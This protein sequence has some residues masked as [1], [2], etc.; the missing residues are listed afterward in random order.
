[1]PVRPQTPEERGVW[2]ALVG[3]WGAYLLGAVYVVGPALGWLLLLAAAA[4]WCGWR[5]AP[6]VV[7]PAAWAWIV[8]MLLMQAALVVGHLDF[9]LGMG[10]LLKSSVGWA[11]GWALL[12]AFVVAGSLSIRLELLARAVAVLSTQTLLIGPLLVLAFLA[13]LPETLYVSPLRAVGGPGPEFF[14]VSLYGINPDNGLPRW[15]LFTPWAPALG[16]VANVFFFI[17]LAERDQR[18]RLAGLAG[19]LLMILLSGSR[20]GLLALPAVWLAGQLLRRLERPALHFAA[21]AACL[22]AALA[23]RPLL[24]AVEDLVARFHAARPESSRVRAALG[25]IA[26]DR[27]AG[28]APLWGHGIVE[29]GPHLVEYMPIGSHHTWFGLLFVKGIIGLLALLAPILW[30]LAVLVAHARREPVAACAL[31]VLLV[32]IAYSFG[33]NLEILSYLIWPGMLAIGIALRELHARAA[34]S[35]RRPESGEIACASS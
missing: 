20:L 6:L 18:W 16:M 9:G 15:R 1:M 13:G 4:R 26:V 27:W 3:M 35:G 10:Q 12:A 22:G 17:V 31:Q 34:T 21:A 30:T 29:R 2:Y 32:I 8:G 5:G 23:A 19:C 7:P 28:E 25:R 11:K 24:L 33:E 14:A